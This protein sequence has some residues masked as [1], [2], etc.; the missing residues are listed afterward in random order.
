[1]GQEWVVINI[2][3]WAS[4][5]RGGKFRE[6]NW[7]RN[8]R[9]QDLL[10]LV[11]GVEGSWAGDRIILYG[12]YAQELPPRVVPPKQVDP[13]IGSPETPLESMRT[14]RELPWSKELDGEE[15]IL[16][17]RNLSAR[18]Y[19]TSRLFPGEYSRNR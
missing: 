6:L 2:D 4:I 15:L 13:T 17:L 1:M 8:F 5:S 3:K 12:E 10:I 19:I 18:E 16:V 11:P 14:T 7:E 9:L